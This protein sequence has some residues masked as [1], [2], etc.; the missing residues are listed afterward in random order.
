MLGNKKSF[1]FLTITQLAAFLLLAN[2]GYGN[3]EFRNRADGYF[4][5]D[6]NESVQAYI[7]AFQDINN[8]LNPSDIP[9]D[10]PVNEE[11]KE[12][13][14]KEGGDGEI[15]LLSFPTFKLFFISWDNISY[16]QKIAYNQACIPLYILFHCWKNFLI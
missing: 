14:E 6:K 1:I 16:S 11:E 2:I 8:P 7:D 12:V 4:F 3:S 15:A 13:E 9:D 10:L 5:N